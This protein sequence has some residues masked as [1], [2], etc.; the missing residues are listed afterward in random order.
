MWEESRHLTKKLAAKYNI[1][2]QFVLLA[3][4][5]HQPATMTKKLGHDFFSAARALKKP[6]GASAAVRGKNI[7][8]SRL[9]AVADL[10]PG[11]AEDVCRRLNSHSSKQYKLGGVKHALV[12]LEKRGKATS[13]NKGCYTKRNY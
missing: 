5:E 10:L 1:D 7:W 6:S 12:A 2:P 4:A 9:N 8:E 3:F 11:S 13:D